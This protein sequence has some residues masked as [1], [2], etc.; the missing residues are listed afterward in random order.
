MAKV[1][2]PISI[3]E[4]V[5]DIDS[6][7]RTAQVL[8]EA[9]EVLQGIRGNRAAVIQEDLDN[10]LG[11][12]D[13]VIAGIEAT[14][15]GA[16]SLTELS[17][18]VDTFT[19]LTDGQVLTYDVTN[20]WQNETNDPNATHTGEVTGSLAL[21]VDV[22]SITNRTAV[23]EVSESGTDDVALH[24]AT[25]GTLKKSPVNLITDGGYF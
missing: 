18:V 17:D 16:T 12:L 1:T 3:P 15:G 6:L 7:W 4:P 19:G 11:D 13:K 23:T 8:K 22:S 24:D 5:A 14:G 25:D 10:A 9:V 21:T 2:A 20:G